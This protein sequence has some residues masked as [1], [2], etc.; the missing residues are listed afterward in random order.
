MSLE[1]A[2]GLYAKKINGTV[3]KHSRS[4]EIRLSTKELV[5][6]NSDHFVQKTTFSKWDSCCVYR[7]VVPP[8][9]ALISAETRPSFTSGKFRKK[10]SSGQVLERL[11][12]DLREEQGEGVLQK[13]IPSWVFVGKHCKT[14]I[15]LFV[16]GN[17]ILITRF[18]LRVSSCGR[19]PTSQAAAFFFNPRRVVVVANMGVFLL[20]F[21][22]GARKGFGH[23]FGGNENS[24]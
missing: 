21:N 3:T 18:L 14:Y 13:N 2:W 11:R 15:F 4:G 20:R 10:R 19:K 16:K 7:S 6:V 23:F 1:T 17:G 24:E 8:Y 12:S 9:P 22:V 5:V